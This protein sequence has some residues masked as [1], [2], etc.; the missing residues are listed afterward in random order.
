M[1]QLIGLS[2][3]ISLG[4]NCP[5]LNIAMNTPNV[6]TFLKGSSAFANVLSFA[7]IQKFCV[8]TKP[9]RQEWASSVHK[10]FHCPLSREQE[11]LEQ[12]NVLLEQRQIVTL[13]HG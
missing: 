3:H 1:V 9:L 7:H 11:I 12:K 10:T 2:G 5:T 13:E 8:L 4:N 6:V